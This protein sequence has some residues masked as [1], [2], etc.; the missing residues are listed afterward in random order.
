MERVSR[1]LC[2]GAARKTFILLS[3]AIQ[4]PF[5]SLCNNTASSIVP[6]LDDARAGTIPAVA[7]HDVKLAHPSPPYAA[8]LLFHGCLRA[9]VFI[10]AALAGL[11][12]P[13]TAI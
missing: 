1:P 5:I 7:P 13:L 12:A 10:S 4:V 3:H 8:N 11:N 2:G 6:V 9:A